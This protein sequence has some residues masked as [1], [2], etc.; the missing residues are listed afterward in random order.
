VLAVDTFSES[1]SG[2]FKPLKSVFSGQT[3]IVRNFAVHYLMKSYYTSLQRRIERAVLDAQELKVRVVGL[4]N[5][6]KA[7][8]LNHGGSDIIKNLQG[9]LH[10]T[11]VAHGDTLSAAT[12]LQYSLQL[13]AA[14]Y[15]R[16]SVFLTGS[17]SKIGRAVAL[18]LAKRG[19]KV[20]MLSQCRERFDEIASELTDPAQRANLIYTDTL[21]GGKACD[22]WLTGK[23]IPKGRPLLD[24]IPRDA[25]IVNFSVPDPLTPSLLKNRPDLLHL[26][27]GLL[28]FTQNTMAPRFNWLLPQ[29]LIY[30][31]LAGC[32]VHS[33]LGINEHEVGP[34][35]VENM[36]MYWNAAIALG[37]SI[38]A[39][40]SFY[41]PIKMPSPKHL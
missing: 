38:P 7:E 19:I 28:S 5:F 27:S 37:F 25:T 40:T 41:S 26:D 3:W 21:A 2:S 31:C 23:M 22:L 32:I 18:A 33:V 16:N 35:K 24:A 20:V 36:D 6:N 13:R 39:P 29:G 8:W 15:W 34:V 11:Y 9:K 17:T 12:V 14:Q 1:S 10:S 4:G 30:A